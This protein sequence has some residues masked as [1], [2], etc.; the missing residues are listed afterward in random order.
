MA[1][2]SLVFRMR[3]L[4]REVL[5]GGV[6][7]SIN[8]NR[9]QMAPVSKV[10]WFLTSPVTNVLIYLQ[11]YYSFIFVKIK[12]KTLKHLPGTYSHAF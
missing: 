11:K 2:T 7:Y 10:K 6:F 1:K 9:K 8:K 12:R 5:R 3:G 4:V